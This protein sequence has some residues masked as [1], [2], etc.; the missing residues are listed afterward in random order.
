MKLQQSK[1]QENELGL[2]FSDVFH[3]LK[4]V[5]YISK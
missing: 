5:I 1:A 3:I 2:H 4:C